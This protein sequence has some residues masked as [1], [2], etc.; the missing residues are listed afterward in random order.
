MKNFSLSFRFIEEEIKSEEGQTIRMEQIQYKKNEYELTLNQLKYIAIAAMVIDHLAVSFLPYES[1][2]AIVMH[3]VGKITGPIMFFAAVEGVHHTGDL[4][5]YIARLGIFAL[6]S[7]IPF[8]YFSQGG[9]LPLS[10][11]VFRPNVI[12]TILLGVLAVCIRR[13]VKNP[14]GKLLGILSLIVLCVRADWGTT[15]ILMIFVFDYF[16]GDFHNQVFGY[17]LVVLLGTEVSN[18][19]FSPFFTLFYEHQFYI[20]AEY[21][22]LSFSDFGMF[23]PLFFLMFYRGNKGATGKNQVFSKWF[24][25]LF[26]PAHLAVLGFLQ[27]LIR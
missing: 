14:I 9:E 18:M 21:Y 26:Y 7:W 2:I 27:S 5:R 20:D 10:T 6:V 12:Y 22:L 8:L 3:T 13:Q 19:I 25:Y 1:P 23:L 17:I 16:Y 11:D 15:G 4:K 24:F